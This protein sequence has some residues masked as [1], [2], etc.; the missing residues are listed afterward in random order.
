[1]ERRER[2]EGAFET[3]SCMNV[4]QRIG[5]VVYECNLTFPESVGCTHC[6][7]ARARASRPSASEQV[8]G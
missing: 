3:W 2:R 8:G 6:L 7:R 5:P 1:M 4:I